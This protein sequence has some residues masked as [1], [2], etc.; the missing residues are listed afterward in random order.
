MYQIKLVVD[1]YE[2]W[3]TG[4]HYEY[5]CPIE[6]DKAYYRKF[7]QKNFP[8][9]MGDAY[10]LHP[11]TNK[12]PLVK[13]SQLDER[14]QQ[15]CM[16]QAQSDFYQTTPKFND[17]CLGEFGESDT[18]KVGYYNTLAMARHKAGLDYGIVPNYT[19][20]YDKYLSPVQNITARTTYNKIGGLFSLELNSSENDDYLYEWLLTSQM[21]Q[22]KLVFYDG[23]G[24]QAF[25]IEFWD[26][27][28]IGVQENM[29]AEGNTAMK[30]NVRL[31]P[32]ITR[33]RSAEHQKVWKVTDIT[34]TN[35]AFGLSS[36]SE[37]PAEAK[38]KDKLLVKKVE[39]PFFENGQVAEEM[40]EG[41][42]YI[43][44]A[45]EY[46]QAEGDKLALTQWAE[47]LS[48][49]GQI[50]NIRGA[51]SYLDNDGVI[52]FKYKAKKAEK[53]RIYAYVES[54][55][56]KVSVKV[57]VVLFPFCVDR[58]K[59]PGLNNEGTNIAEDLTYGRGVATKT[60]NTVYDS[61]SIERFK[62]EYVETGFEIDKH[63]TFANIDQ[64]KEN[65]F[66][67]PLDH[68]S[69]IE[70]SDHF[71]S[72]QR[73]IDAQNN[74]KMMKMADDFD[75]ANYPKAIYSKERIYN[76]K[77]W[78]IKDWVFEASGKDVK[79]YHEGNLMFWDTSDENIFKAFED[80]ATACYA[81]GEMQ[82]NIKRMI[83]KFKRNE[84]GIY[85]DP[86]LTKDIA[87]HKST[88]EYCSNLE[89][90]IAEKI[91]TSKGKLSEIIETDVDYDYNARGNRGKTTAKGAKF[92]K[93][94]FGS[95]KDT[96]KGET[97]ALNDIWATEVHVSEVEFD[98]D[99]YKMKYEVTLW[100]H[101]GLDITDIEDIP[102]T[103]PLA[104]EAFA[105]WFA[106]Q[107]L[108]GYKP[109][110]TKITFNKE[111]NGNINEGKIERND[112]RE[113]LNAKEVKERID[114]LPKFKSL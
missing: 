67:K 13:R 28:C 59:V 100:D 60:P 26:C 34:P 5:F 69:P 79:D 8:Y 77:A 4:L 72:V 93:P 108:R 78:L 53:I 32:A 58:F 101:F 106:L 70:G 91:K 38:Q 35:R 92:A 95:F 16:R 62:K 1:S 36:V 94:T 42:T 97:I 88:L 9:E 39:G 27:F 56:E 49:D 22:G 109:F 57:P 68:S 111:F 103:V 48:D 114:N 64:L 89:D 104:K 102:N 12:L 51:K 6:V 24:D 66:D 7:L 107:H 61:E 33:N 90:F 44:K 73:D 52:C 41:N 14:L 55:A 81:Y 105:A 99:N 80:W 96:L 25:K 65:P 30:M 17:L 85:E 84:G 86:V 82:G 71:A 15:D 87:N 23:D 37:E 3:L 21:R 2:R 45:T 98:N 47:Q 63:A 76:A 50:T 74:T 110:I 43:Y 113:A 11:Y 29:S 40:I 10:N 112:K 19:H 75:K 20:N 31:S 18:K 46:T 54:A 83:A